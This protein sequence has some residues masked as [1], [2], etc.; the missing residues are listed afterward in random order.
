MSKKDYYVIL[1][2]AKTSTKDEIKA[3]YRKLALKYHPDRNPGDKASESKFKE[4][5]EAYEVLSSED[6]RKQYDQLGHE[7]FTNM[8]SGGGDQW[9]TSGMSMDDIFSNFSDI[10]DGMFGGGFGGRR[11]TEKAGPTPLRGHDLAKEIKVTLEESYVGS[12]EEIGYYHF[13]SCETCNG[14]GMKPG[15]TTTECNACKGHGQIQYRQGFFAYSQTCGTC[16]GQGYTIP[17]PCTDCSGQSRV[18]K[19]D[20]F[21]VSIPAGIYDGAEL[22]ISSKGDAGIY[23]GSSGNLYLKITVVPD[24]KFS[25]EDND[26]VCSVMLTYPQLVLGCQVEIENIDGTKETIKV[27]KS[28]T[29]GEKITVKGKGFPSIKRGTRG[30]LIII[31]QC[32][33]PKKLSTESKNLLKEYSE[34]IGTDTKDSDSS[35]SGF[36]KKFL[37]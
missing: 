11:R 24:K 6:K 15:T 37:G 22:R 26:L 23:G 32:H 14:N 1:G 34:Q 25:R 3:A 2:V 30:N 5:A 33:I 31:A 36:F 17:N 19:Y 4:A 20:K 29:V 9:Q 21:K 18:Q 27:P 12:K 8:G 28:C 13:V 10:F 7:G 35:I 16:S